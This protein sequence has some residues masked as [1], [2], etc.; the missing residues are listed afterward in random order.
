MFA[1]KKVDHHNVFDCVLDE[2]AFLFKKKVGDKVPRRSQAEEMN[3]FLSGA[4]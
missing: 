4:L 2:K 3:F 1:K